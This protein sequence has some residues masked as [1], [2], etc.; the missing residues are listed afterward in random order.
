MY[1][2]PEAIQSICLN[3][4]QARHDIIH[5]KEV[6]AMTNVNVPVEM[7]EDLYQK[8]QSLCDELGLDMDTAINIFAQKMV[9]E[10]GMPFEVTDKDLPV[11][12]QAEKR[13]R[14]LKI[15]G[16][17]A[18]VTSVISAVALIVSLFRKHK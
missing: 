12:E 1:R 2:C 4:W 11:D 6:K 18:L 3:I 10:Q 17:I 14:L 8:L 16:I 5:S 9:N 13:G 15:A 7:N